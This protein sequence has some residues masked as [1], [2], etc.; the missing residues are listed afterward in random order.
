MAYTQRNEPNP[1]TATGSLSNT[2][3][4]KKVNSAYRRCFILHELPENQPVFMSTWI[5]KHHP[6]Q[7]D[8]NAQC[9]LAKMGILNG[10]SSKAS[11]WETD[12]R[13]RKVTI[14]RSARGRGAERKH[15][16]QISAL[17]P[18][19]I[20]LTQPQI[21]IRWLSQTIQN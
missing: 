19:E 18:A 12:R 13:L 11:P 10:S 6:K 21:H 7:A 8:D 4:S 3:R 17:V 16:I 9:Y 2:Y 14:L 20:S 1:L 15:V 5:P